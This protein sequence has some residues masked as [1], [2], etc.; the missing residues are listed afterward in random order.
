MSSYNYDLRLKE[1]VERSCGELLKND[2]FSVSAFDE[3]YEYLVEK[4]ISIKGEY[5]LSK[6][7]VSAIFQVKNTIERAGEFNPDVKRNAA[8]ASKFFDALEI[9]SMGE[10]LGD[11]MPGV[12]RI[13]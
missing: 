9:M 5:V 12:P 6:Q 4:S 1:L 2:Y 8:L 7:L 11:R 3:L 10:A 13:T